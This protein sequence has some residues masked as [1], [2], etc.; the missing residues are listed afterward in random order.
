MATICFLLSEIDLSVGE[1]TYPP[2]GRLGPRRQPHLE[3]VLVHSGSAAITVDGAPRALL[4]AGDAGLLLP[5][6]REQFAFAADAP[7][8]HAWIEGAPDGA[9]LERLAALPAALPASTALTDLIGAAVAAARTP[10]STAGP[11]V[12][13]LASA[14]LWRYVGEAEGG[15]GGP[16]DAVERALRHLHAQL[17]DP[18]LDLAQV[19]RAAHVTPA[20]LV[21][22]FHAELGVTPIA[23]LW[24][25][26]VASGIDL[27]ANTGLPVGE[28]AARTGFR[29]VYHFSR[30]VR[31][32]TGR[33]P[34]EVRR[35]RWQRMVD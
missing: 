17:A 19:A 7:T 25:R 4:G 18:G 1:V 24:Q 5:G 27:L 13:A 16:G 35:A 29:S 8:R 32:Q 26:R 28:I 22:R 14:A 3:L 20:H 23:Y 6:H 15:A 30:R 21:R 33:P 2:G 34:T 9:P 10:L 31:E 11:L 12:A